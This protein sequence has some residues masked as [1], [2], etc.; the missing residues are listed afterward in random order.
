MKKIYKLKINKKK[1]GMNCLSLVDRPAVEV[2]F[3]VFD[4][5]EIELKEIEKGIL[6]GPICLANKK[7][8]RRD[9][10][11]GEY[12]VEFDAETIEDMIV[13][14]FREGGF[15]KFNIHHNEDVSDVFIIETWSV[16]DP[17]NDKANAL[18]FKNIVKGD[19]YV[20]CKVEN[21]IVLEKIKSGELKGFSLE[22]FFDLVVEESEFEN[23][24]QVQD[25]FETFEEFSKRYDDVEFF[26]SENK[27]EILKNIYDESF[28]QLNDEVRFNL[29]DSIVNSDISDEEFFNFSQK[30]LNEDR[31]FLFAP[32]RNFI[33]TTSAG[34]K[35]KID[36]TRDF[37]RKYAGGIYNVDFIEGQMN[38][39][40]LKEKSRIPDKSFVGFSKSKN[41]HKFKLKSYLYNC[42]HILVPI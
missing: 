30:I 5:Q 25:E 2:D 7:I 38:K 19:W 20:S 41:P 6:T 4:S 36:N 14:Y 18:K 3:L 26:S 22:G 29:L 1:D 39:D 31:L 33:Y 17:K 37:C 32:T 15:N 24:F 11:R 10:I 42:R 27:S 9:E 16:L 23:D 35:L 28:L 40:L 21:Q 8:L 12:Y 13:K 34:D